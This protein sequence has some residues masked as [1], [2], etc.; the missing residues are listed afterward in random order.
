MA[1]NGIRRLA[2]LAAAVAGVWLFSRYLLGI[3]APFLLAALLAL[4]A[5]PLVKFLNTRLHL[6][7]GAAAGIGVGTALI[8][9]VLLLALLVALLLREL[10]A[11]ADALP[12]ME[13]A[14]KD[15]MDALEQSALDAAQSLPEAV[16]GIAQLG[17]EGLFSDGAALMDRVSA[18]L[19]SIASGVLLAL[20]DSALGVGTWALASFMISAKLPAIRQWVKARLPDTG[21][22]WLPHL[23]KLKDAVSGWLIAQVKLTGITLCVLTVGFLVL[24]IPFAPVWAA[25]VSLVDALP[26]LG[27]GTVLIPWSL[28]CLL[29]G[30]SARAIGLLGVYAGGSLIRSVM[31]PRLVGKQLG[32]DPLVTLAALYAGYRL[33]GLGG[34]LLSP[35]LALAV[36]QAADRE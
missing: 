9:T 12:D 33:W 36:T 35:L 18:R 11:L 3:A 17:V 13:Q 16:R 20:P 21:R 32:L 24:Q 6:P 1:S 4:A 23:Q 28:V 27:T 30:N 7:R 5:E 22:R 2:L 29:Q 8:F 15:G 34:M 25:A 14:A 10:R 26:V 31:E 19:L